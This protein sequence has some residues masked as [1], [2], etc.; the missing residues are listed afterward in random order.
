MESESRVSEQES[1]LGVMGGSQSLCYPVKIGSAQVVG[2]WTLD[3][4][5]TLTISFETFSSFNFISLL[6]KPPKNKIK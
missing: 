4:G 1:I 5:L 2:I 3:S 6:G